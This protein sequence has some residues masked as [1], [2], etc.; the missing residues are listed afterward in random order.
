MCNILHNMSVLK[1][2]MHTVGQAGRAVRNLVI[3]SAQVPVVAIPPSSSIYP[4]Q[5]IQDSVWRAIEQSPKGQLRDQ[6]TLYEM[7]RVKKYGYT[8]AS[9]NGNTWHPDVIKTA[10][11]ETKRILPNSDV[12]ATYKYGYAAR[13]FP[14]NHMP[15]TSHSYICV[16]GGKL[17]IDPLYRYMLLLHRGHISRM[18]SPY[19]DYLY[20]TLP[21]VLVG[22]VDEIRQVHK[23]AAAEMAKDPQHADVV[24]GDT[25]QWVTDPAQSYNHNY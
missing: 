13:A 1:T 19:A 11:E 20:G 16:D 12:R 10:L 4:V 3:S 6:C 24:M 21:P 2:I 9:Y 25:M 23:A 14:D 22:S 18:V 17:I 8:A 15:T 5:E 7:Q